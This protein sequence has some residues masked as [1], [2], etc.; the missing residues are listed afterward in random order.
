VVTARPTRAA[1]T[2]A[3][4]ALCASMRRPRAPGKAGAAGIC[5][6][7]APYRR[8]TPDQVPVRLSA[9]AGV[10]TWTIVRSS[11]RRLHSKVPFLPT[12]MV[13]APSEYDV[14]PAVRTHSRSVRPIPRPV[15]EPDH[16]LAVSRAGVDDGRLRRCRP[17]R[18]CQGTDAEGARR[19]V[20]ETRHLARNCRRV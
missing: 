16:P 9:P 8:L 6:T 4:V 1:A 11:E 7:A 2:R 17:A 14:C 18:T 15:V 10:S 5:I 19:A 20:G 13:A 12:K 3:S